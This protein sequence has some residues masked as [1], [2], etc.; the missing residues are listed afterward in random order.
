MNEDVLQETAI[1][2]LNGQAVEL[3]NDGIQKLVSALNMYLDI[4]DGEK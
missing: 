4:V 2:W 1:G 3:F